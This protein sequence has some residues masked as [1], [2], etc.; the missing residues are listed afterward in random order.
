MKPLLT[1]RPYTPIHRNYDIH[2]VGGGVFTL[3]A[4]F[5]VLLTVAMALASKQPAPHAATATVPTPTVKPLPTPNGL[6]FEGYRP[7]KIHV[8]RLPD[9]P[10]CDCRD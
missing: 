7:G 1:A 10:D 3:T 4:L 2:I 9:G 5:I 6:Y 8:E